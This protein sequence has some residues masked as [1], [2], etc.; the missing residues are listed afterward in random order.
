MARKSFEKSLQ[1]YKKIKLRY[2]LSS[3][4][5]RVLPN[6]IIIGAQKGGTSSLYKNLIRHPSVK[7][8]FH[9]E[10]HF[11]DFNYFEGISWYKA[12][13][14]RETEMNNKLTGEATPYYLFHPKAPKRVKETQPD[15]KLLVML[16]NPVNRAYSH[17]N[18]DSLRGKDPL[19]FIDAVHAEDQRFEE[20]KKQYEDPYKCINHWKR[21]YLSRGKYAEQLERW[22]KFF[23]R[24]QF[25]I[26]QSE[27]YYSNASKIYSDVLN[28]LDLPEWDPKFISK[29]NIG[30]YDKMNE[31]TK[32]ELTEYFE[33][34][35][36]KLYSLL[37]V[38][39]DW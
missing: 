36:Q 8:S 35:N 20:E 16:R 11:Y 5:H 18:K 21:S 14:P 19:S 39:Y 13:F 31:D 34:Y 17:Y 23:P 37:G 10:P 6:F 2:N 29:H 26:I 15:V 30:K 9:K 33:P 27:Q 24:K 22:F 1:F 4:S 25:L 32:K 38:A 28:F 12:F 7:A 3:S